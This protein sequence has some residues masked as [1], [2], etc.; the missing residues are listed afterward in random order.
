[1]TAT[2]LGNGFAMATAPC[3]QV[4]SIL[5]K[6]HQNLTEIDTRVWLSDARSCCDTARLLLNGRCHGNRIM[7]DMF[8][9]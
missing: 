9:T 5:A 4:E 2:L 7:A 3:K 8:G 6:Y 1:L